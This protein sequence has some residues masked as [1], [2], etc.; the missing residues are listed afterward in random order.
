MSNDD[1]FDPYWLD[2]EDWLVTV[3]PLGEWAQ[4]IGKGKLTLSNNVLPL[5][6]QGDAVSYANASVS[7]YGI[8]TKLSATAS[9]TIAQGVC[10]IQSQGPNVAVKVSAPK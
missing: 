3:C 9:A 6:H 1:N 10:L 7:I 4:V 2:E 5:I 8:E